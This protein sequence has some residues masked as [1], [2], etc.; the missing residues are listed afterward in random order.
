MINNVL[1]NSLSIN[2]QTQAIGSFESIIA[3]TNISAKELPKL[4]QKLVCNGLDNIESGEQLCKY[5]L[6]KIS[7]T[8]DFNK[9]K[10]TSQ[11]NYPYDLTSYKIS[12]LAPSV[13]NPKSQERTLKLVSGLVV[14]PQIKTPKGVIIYFHG[15]T[16]AKNSVPSQFNTLFLHQLAEVMA[17]QGYIVIAPDYLGQGI[18]NTEPHPYFSYPE[19][20]AKTGIYMLKALRGLLQNIQSQLSFDANLNFN[21]YI[22][23]H[24]EGG[25][26]TLW[27]IFLLQYPDKLDPQINQLPHQYGFNIKHAYSVSGIYD[28]KGLLESELFSNIDNSTTNPHKIGFGSRA[29]NNP[30]LDFI[31]NKF[32]E[33]Y[34]ENNLHIA[35][36]NYE[37]LSEFSALLRNA[38]AKPAILMYWLNGFTYYN[39]LNNADYYTK[40]NSTYL[41]NCFDF[42]TLT[43]D[44]CK[45]SNRQQYTLASLF[46]L[47]QN[48]LTN[49][50]IFN[51][52][53]FSAIN[54][55]YLITPKQLSQ[56]NNVLALMFESNTINNDMSLLINSKKLLNDPNFNQLLNKAQSLVNLP[57]KSQIPITLIG[58]DYDSLV[59]PNNNQI[60]YN[61]LKTN[62]SKIE[63][64]EL[65]SSDYWTSEPNNALGIYNLDHHDFPSYINHSSNDIYAI[66]IM[67]KQ[68]AQ[69]EF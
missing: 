65:K 56:T 49:L 66:L 53:L 67:L 69:P 8:Q 17:S 61:H 39:H 58:L 50:E 10:I 16:L 40:Q 14:I 64:F 47:D 42:N 12:Y 2:Q 37:K 28:F 35:N 48:Q 1:A 57:W 34:I 21:T 59:N 20:Q 51:N 31:A 60:M 36:Q 33:S 23:G 11:S 9:F 22:Y 43:I 26:N 41:T 13:P 27:S 29:G 15:T 55:N 54:A 18:D 24:S 30:L 45:W 46:N 5:N 4:A 32:G 38:S 68:L 6:T 44:K 52:L 7:S 3:T 25:T 62:N 63:Y 19:V